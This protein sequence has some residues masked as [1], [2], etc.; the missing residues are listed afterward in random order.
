MTRI[1]SHPEPHANLKELAEEVLYRP[2]PAER[3]MKARYWS[4]M[5]DALLLGEPTQAEITR[6]LGGNYLSRS[7]PKEGFKEWFLNK[8]EGRA[9]LEYLF[10]LGLDAMETILTDPDPKSNAA[11]VAAIKMLAELTGRSAKQQ[12]TKTSAIADAIA[13]AD[14][15][16][17]EAMF[18]SQGLVVSLTA[19]KSEPEPIN[20]TPSK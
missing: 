12:A 4:V 15:A 5:G 10:D 16:Q 7:F 8:E 19:S 2:T 11:K 20:V 13:G 17:L 9:R 3:R 14:K 18:Q 1:S 6:T